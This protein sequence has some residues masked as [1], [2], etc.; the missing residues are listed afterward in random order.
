MR[1]LSLKMICIIAVLAIA[2]FI[3]VRPMV[4]SLLNTNA[5]APKTALS[6]TEKAML[7]GFSEDCACTVQFHHDQAMASRTETVDSPA[8][9]IVFN[10]YT[11]KGHE[12]SDRVQGDMCARDSTF[13]VLHATAVAKKMTATISYRNLYRF[14]VVHYTT[15]EIYN[16]ELSGSKCNKEVRFR[17]MENDSLGFERFTVTQSK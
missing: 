11:G 4:I 13:L 6:E 1:R 12:K 15:T 5:F 3:I 2:L 16:D 10:W 17:L 8:A 9:L 14:I 7:A